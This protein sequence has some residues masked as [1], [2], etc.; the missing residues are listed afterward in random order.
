MRIAKQHLKFMCQ[1]YEEQSIR[2]A[3][4]LHEHPATASSWKERCILDVMKMPE[5]STVVG[6]QCRFGLT[7]HIRGKEMA[8]GKNPVHE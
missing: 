7:T 6:D 3:W 8:A 4:L 5:V 1:I 2:G